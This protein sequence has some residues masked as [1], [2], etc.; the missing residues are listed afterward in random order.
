M[1]EYVKYGKSSVARETSASQFGQI[2]NGTNFSIF[3]IEQ[4]IDNLS[5]SLRSRTG[6]DT[7]IIAQA[8]GGGGHVYASGARLEGL[9]FKEAVNKVLRVARKYAKKNKIFNTK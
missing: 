5:V 1:Y 2:I 4:E 7:S 3:M 9:P 8:L 6:F